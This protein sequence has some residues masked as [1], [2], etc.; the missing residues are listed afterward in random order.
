MNGIDPW[1]VAGNYTLTATQMVLQRSVN[2]KVKRHLLSIDGATEKEHGSQH[3]SSSY[4][5]QTTLRRRLQRT[6][7]L[8][9]RVRACSGNL[10]D[11]VKAWLTWQYSAA[12]NSAPVVEV[13]SVGG[14]QEIT[15]ATGMAGAA[16][17]FGGLNFTA[18]P[19][20]VH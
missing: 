11:T 19:K 5:P 9:R 1:T 3:L 16:T 8:S 13:S 2:T 15:L 6:S 17:T 10:V 4:K 7:Q 20:S 14:G 12:V 18:V